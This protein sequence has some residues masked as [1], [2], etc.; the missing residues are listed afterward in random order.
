METPPQT[1]FETPIWG[2]VLTEHQHQAV[3]YLNKITELSQQNETTIKSNFG[4][5]QSDDYLHQQP[6]FREVIS[7]I[8]NLCNVVASNYLGT[9]VSGT[10]N[11]CWANVNYRH[12]FN[13]HHVHGGDL[14]GV[15][16]LQTPEQSGKLVFVNPAVRAQSRRFAHSNYG[17]Q[18]QPLALIIFPSWLEHYVEPNLTDTP[19][20]SMSFNYDINN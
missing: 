4:G 10:I 17:L 19:R 5:W 16:F 15:F 13:A 20:V 14:S 1:A 12:C 8:T 6:I 11:E 2:F 3:D 7:T 9:Q 18:P